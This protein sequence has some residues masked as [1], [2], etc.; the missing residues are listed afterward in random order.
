MLKDI[1]I[2]EQ[3][4]I[5]EKPNICAFEKRQANEIM[6]ILKYDEHKGT[7]GRLLVVGGSKEMSGAIVMA[8]SAAMRAGSGIVKMVVP[9][10]IWMAVMS[11]TCEVMI[12]PVKHTIYGTLS[13]QNL[14]EILTMSEKFDAMVIGCGM[15]VNENTKELLYG[16]IQS[17]TKP[18]VIDAD[19]IN[20]VAQNL[21]I[22]AEAQAPI[23]L[24]PHIVEMSR[25]CGLSVE[26]LKRDLIEIAIGF[27]K[28]YNITLVLKDP[29]TLTVSQKGNVFINT[30]GN[31]GMATAGSGDVLAG[32]V[33]SF[34]ARGIQPFRA[35]AAGVY[36]HGRAGDW[37]AE[38][39]SQYGMMAT[40]IIAHIPYT[41]RDYNY[42]G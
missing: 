23:V 3:A 21:D 6:P 19:G 30:S 17:C 14:E 37:A 16:I 35:A 9:E 1:G 11:R 22:L 28:K 4:I 10:N 8:A 26:E 5:D 20:I 41:L 13:K 2:P 25:L 18:M 40:D 24:T 27:A 31:P 42:M 12:S 38:R 7:N 15:A 39:L 34:V 33:G 32:I 36:V 29:N